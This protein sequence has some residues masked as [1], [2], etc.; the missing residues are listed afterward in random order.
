MKSL[1]EIKA[2]VERLAKLIDALQP[3]LPDWGSSNQG[4]HP[5]IEVDGL[6]YHYVVVERGTEFERMTTPDLDELLYAVFRDVTDNIAGRY[7][8]YHRVAEHDWRR[9]SYKK[10]I[11]LIAALSPNWAERLSDEIKKKLELHPFND[12]ADSPYTS[13]QSRSI[14][15]KFARLLT[16]VTAGR[17][18][19]RGKIMNLN[20]LALSGDEATVNEIV[21]QHA[22]EFAAHGFDLTE[23][24]L[25]GSEET[26][27]SLD[28][29]FLN[30]RTA[31]SIDI[32]FFAAVRGLN[33]G[34]NV[35][36][37]GPDNRMLFV[38]DF[39][40]KHGREA[41]TEFFTYRDPATNLHSFAD[42]FF[43]V[44]VGLLDSDLKP[45]L[46]GEVFEETPIDWMG[47][48]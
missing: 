2:E 35:S 22:S 28:F 21:Q 43:R 24:T 41:L 31:M 48:K 26:V 16:I 4:G 30:E 44:L 19:P 32:S 12:A 29:N 46:E 27:R 3:S 1:D 8:A 6:G 37:F 10:Q 13:G 17:F 15:K 23:V 39:L 47:F 25:K 7:A 9:W 36:I 42:T 5:H 40:K 11:E 33:G 38:D 34:F 14:L 20:V 45:I 18:P